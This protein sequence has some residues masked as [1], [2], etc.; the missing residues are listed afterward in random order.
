[1]IQEFTLS[2]A[3]KITCE[4]SAA[5]KQLKNIN[6]GNLVEK[7][8]SLEQ[9]LIKIESL[10]QSFEQMDRGLME[11]KFEE[12]YALIFGHLKQITNDIYDDESI[13]RLESLIARAEK[14][15]N[16]LSYRLIIFF[17]LATGFL[18]YLEKHL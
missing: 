2:E 1:M 12:A 14:V 10:L 16:I 5:A 7:I 11:H 18:I 4:L 17:T 15:K 3:Q 9:R 13:N 6:T 8:T